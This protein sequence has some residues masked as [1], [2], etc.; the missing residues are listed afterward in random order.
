MHQRI[1]IETAISGEIGD[2][3]QAAFGQSKAAN[4]DIKRKLACP[5]A[6]LCFEKLS[7]ICNK[8]KAAA[9][10]AILS[11]TASRSVSRMS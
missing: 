8:S 9:R 10:T 11:K 6:N 7:V 2:N 3:E 4:R 1:V 5:D